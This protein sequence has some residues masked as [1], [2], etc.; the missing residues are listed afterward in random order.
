MEKKNMWK[1]KNFVLLFIGKLSSTIGGSFYHF[2]IGWYLLDIT[3][4]AL[5]MSIYLAI[6]M[7]LRIV[8]TPVLATIADRGN[9]KKIM[10]ITDFSRGI[11]QVILAFVILLL[12]NLDF[13]YQFSAI[14]LF[15]VVQVII[16]SLFEPASTGIIMELA[17][18]DEIQSY[19]ALN[20]MATNLSQLIGV[21]LSGML[22][23]VL[24]I[25]GI[26]IVDGITFIL[27]GLTETF[28]KPTIKVE[29]KE[30]IE[31]VKHI[32]SDLKE[33]FIYIKTKQT[34]MKLITYLIL[35]NFLFAAI[36]SVI[37]P[38]MFN[39]VLKTTPFIY[40]LIGISFS[41]G[42]ILCSLLLTS[43]KVKKPINLM[44]LL[45]FCISIVVGLFIVVVYL[46]FI[47]TYSLIIFI[48]LFMI[49]QVLIGGILVLIN[50]PFMTLGYKLIPESMIGKVMS[51]IG[52]LAMSAS[53]IG[54]IIFGVLIDVMDVFNLATI[55]VILC[56]IV[57]VSFYLSVSEEKLIAEFSENNN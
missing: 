19:N 36:F 8:A 3:G 17:E 45:I 12:S 29:A 16:G 56:L 7:L 33:T 34:M 23:G 11:I 51:F 38:Y 2:A 39:V 52:T 18:K 50:T 24:G 6:T 1:N 25:V 22:Y 30:K 37:T 13:I 28:I 31:S 47:D 55:I 14:V 9:R 46:Y 44:K 26:L 53:P 32:F 42:A 43:I 21:L 54:I 41:I 10:V 40:S 48:M 15:G 49:T 20:S 27:S 57:S 35:I 5:F 4:K